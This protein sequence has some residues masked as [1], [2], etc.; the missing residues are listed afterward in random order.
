MHF[1]FY[2]Y[3]NFKKD[4]EQEAELK[5]RAKELIEEMQSSNSLT[6]TEQKVA[7]NIL[8]QLNLPENRKF[9]NFVNLDMLLKGPLVGGQIKF[10]D[11]SVSEIAEQMTYVDYQIF[12]SI[13]SE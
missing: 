13:Q 1:E 5:N 10:S 2:L 12:C 7:N 3:F 8:Q 11:L 6:R 9:E 4:F